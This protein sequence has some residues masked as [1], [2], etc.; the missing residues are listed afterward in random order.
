MPPRHSVWT[1]SPSPTDPEA[2][3]QELPGDPSLRIAGGTTAESVIRLLVIE[4]NEFDQ[5]E[6][7]RHMRKANIR[8]HILFIA[9]GRKAIDLLLQDKLN[10]RSKIFAVFLDLNLP[11]A[12]GVEILRAI[13][14]TP[15]IAHF[16]VIVMT[17]LANP[18]DMAECEKLKATS[19][20]PK[21]IGFQAFCMALA[22]V[23]HLPVSPSSSVIKG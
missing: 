2:P 12:S 6:L 1:V 9:D 11:K 21:P 16:P 23:F 19:Y 20:I 15:E 14:S 3:P 8:E 18:K 7:L 17:G 22:N 10:I 4:D 13:R 5:E